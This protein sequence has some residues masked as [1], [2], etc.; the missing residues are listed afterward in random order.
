MGTSGHAI[1]MKALQPTGAAD[2]IVRRQKVDA[3]RRID[4]AT[5]LLRRELSVDVDCY[6]CGSTG[7]DPCFTKDGFQ[8]VQCQTCE[9]VYV[10]PRLC[11]DEIHQLYAE[12]GRGAYQFEH[13]YLPS[14]GLSQ[15][16]A[17]SQT[18]GNH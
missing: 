3:Q 4:P 9:L 18:V 14:A 8:F 11:D 12:G 1:D 6:V 13:F 15:N 17:V 5:G 2:E 10:N 16:N 7:G